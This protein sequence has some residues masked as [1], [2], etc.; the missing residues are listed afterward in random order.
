M[1]SIL[2]MFCVPPTGLIAPLW[3]E[4]VLPAHRRGE[5]LIYIDTALAS[6]VVRVWYERVRYV[7]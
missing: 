1:E 2:H 7:K 6:L 5:A 4:T 3:C